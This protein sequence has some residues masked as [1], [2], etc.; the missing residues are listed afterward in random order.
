MN[1]TN[2]DRFYWFSIFDNLKKIEEY[3]D[4]MDEFNKKFSQLK[5]GVISDSDKNIISGIVERYWKR[6]ISERCNKTKN[7]I[8]KRKTRGQSFSDELE[9]V[10]TIQNQAEKETEY[11]NL[12]DLFRKLENINKKV[13]EKRKIEKY[14]LSLFGWGLTLGFI[15]GII[16]NYILLILT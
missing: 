2:D 14:N 15:L 12:L 13:D 9:K 6:I 1:Y 4:L 3:D 16:G 11:E 8:E 7:N 5:E 10:N